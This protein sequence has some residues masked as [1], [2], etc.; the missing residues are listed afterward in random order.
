M[1]ELAKV[2]QNVASEVAPQWPLPQW[3]A[4]NPFWEQRQQPLAQVAADWQYNSGTSLLMS[5]EFYQQQRQQGNI[6]PALVTTAMDE[7][8]QPLLAGKKMSPRWEHLTRLVDKYQQRRRK[9]RWHDEVVFQISQSCGLFMQFPQRFQR[10]GKDTSLYRHWL[11]ISRADRGIETLMDESDLN[12]LFAELPDTPE[13]LLEACRSSYLSSASDPALRFYCQAL[14]ADLLGWASSLSYQDRRQGSRWV[15]ELLCIRLAWDYLVWQ[16]A[17]KTNRSVFGKLQNDF[18]AQLE[19]CQQ[20]VDELK[21]Q[22]QILWQWQA[23]YEQSQLKTLRFEA[24]SAPSNKP[25]I[26]AV[27]CIDVRSERFRRA[28]EKIG[29]SHGS[30]VQTKGFA[31]FFGVPVAQ[32]DKDGN[33]VP[34]VPGLLQPGFHIN[35]KKTESPGKSLLSQLFNS[36]TS[37]FSGIEALGLVKLKALLTGA[38]GALDKAFDPSTMTIQC[39]QQQANLQQLADV[40][41]QALAGMQFTD[42]AEQIVLVGHGAKHTN[43]AQRAG[44]NCGACGGQTG[45]LSARVLCHLLNSPEIRTELSKRDIDIPAQTRFFAALHETVTDD[46]VWLS[47]DI[48]DST[49]VLFSRASQQ[50]TETSQESATE[51]KRRSSNWAELRPEWGLADNSLL[52]FGNARR[53]ASDNPVGRSFLH[54]Y[55]ASNDDDAS[56]LTQLLSA[57]GLVANWINWQYYSSVTAPQRLGSGNKLL[58]NRVCNDIG[59]FEGNGGDLQIGLAW[60]SVHNGE[61]LMHRPVRLQVVIEASEDAINKAL[62]Q[63]EDFNQLYKNRWINVLRL[64]E[65]GELCPLNNH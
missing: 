10:H 29:Q 21:Q 46:I 18:S 31:G 16:L 63:A 30:A 54:D 8:L 57:P 19:C 32:Q 35:S 26:Q 22:Q 2:A 12:E 65:R 43:N 39:G 11:T 23:A 53:L 6:D 44:L 40:C 20:R 48:S 14:I 36:P 42:F 7:H 28:L 37:M 56:L 49:K 38:D 33:Q 3:V 17:D 13:A 64:D 60:Q 61:Q 45:A 47:D 5:A 50:L 25:E 41:Q 55:D 24:P 4:V 62:N 15:F 9:M 52:F 51:R 34:H 1:I 27:F 59:V 58:H